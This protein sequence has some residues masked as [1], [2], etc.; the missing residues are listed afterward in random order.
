MK[1]YE[2]DSIKDGDPRDLLTSPLGLS[3]RLSA[4]RFRVDT[5]AF[6]DLGFIC[7]LVLLLSQNFI[8]SPGVEIDLPVIEGSDTLLGVHADAVATVW[9][10]EIVTRLGS[11]PFGR[12][13]T[14]FRDLRAETPAGGDTLL[15]LTSQATALESLTGIFESARAAGFDHVQI[16]A[17]PS[18]K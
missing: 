11:Y 14:A 1:S 18:Q 4:P 8:F 7:L 15:L 5:I 12:M 3:D 13:D 17:K 9:Q 16:A 10:G 6:A 2:T